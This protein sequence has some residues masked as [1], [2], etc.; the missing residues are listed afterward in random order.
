MRRSIWPEFEGNE[1]RCPKCGAGDP[2][3]QLLVDV[4]FVVE[5]V[6]GPIEGKN[7]IRYRVACQPKRDGLALHRTDTYTASG[8]PRATTCRSCQTTPPW[9]AYAKR[10]ET[11]RHMLISGEAGCCG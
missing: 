8:D 5:D 1:A 7:G 11:L 2:A 10:F 6:A 3:V 4:H 9:L